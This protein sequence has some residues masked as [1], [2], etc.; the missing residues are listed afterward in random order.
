MKVTPKSMLKRSVA[1]L[2]KGNTSKLKQDSTFK[3][4]FIEYTKEQIE[5]LR[6]PVYTPFKL[7]VR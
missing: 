7:N 1:I 2:S 3:P 5:A 6:S 4:E